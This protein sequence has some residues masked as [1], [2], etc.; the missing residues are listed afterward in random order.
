MVQSLM[1]VS[2]M[3][4]IGVPITVAW[5]QIRGS[6]GLPVMTLFTFVAIVIVG[7]AL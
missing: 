4:L 2:L 7:G 5:A 3:V 6:F 1:F